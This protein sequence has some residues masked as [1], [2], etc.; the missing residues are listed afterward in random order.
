VKIIK[1]NVLPDPIQGPGYA[2]IALE[3]ASIESAGD[4]SFSIARNQDGRFLALSGQWEPTETWHQS[5][6]QQVGDAI[7]RCWVGTHVVD[8]L[9]ANPQMQYRIL[10]RAGDATFQGIMRLSTDLFPSSARLDTPAAATLKPSPELVTPAF[11]SASEVVPEPAPPAS[12]PSASKKSIVLLLV[13]GLVALALIGAGLWSFLNG[14]DQSSADVLAPAPVVE[15]MVA[16]P[17]SVDA[18]TQTDDDIAYLQRCVQSTPSTEQVL[19]V[20]AAGK[21]ARKCDLIQRLYAHVAQT[22]NSG[23]ALAYAKEFDPLTFSGG[24]FS[25]PEPA[26]ALYW[27]EL[28]LQQKPDD[29]AIVT[30]AKSLKE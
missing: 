4:L 17:C 6:E 29:Q 27:Y 26:T 10:V 28:Y 25:A 9:L 21:S 7:V 2:I 24:C 23:V 1:V 8:A 11:E 30:L 13:L 3:G 18:L 16:V 5:Q 12:P 15:P 20:I 14:A 22:G 19:A